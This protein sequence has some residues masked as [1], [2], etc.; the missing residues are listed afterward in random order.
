VSRARALGFRSPLGL[1]AAE[2]LDRSTRC[3]HPGLEF[4]VPRLFGQRRDAAPLFGCFV[5]L[6]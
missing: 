1:L 3:R 2:V 6:Q 4:F 5:E